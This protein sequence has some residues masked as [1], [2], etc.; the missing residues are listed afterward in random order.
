MRLLLRRLASSDSVAG[1]GLP[2][3][4]SPNWK[5]GTSE[6]RSLPH[7]TS[8]S[9][10]STMNTLAPAHPQHAWS[11][12]VFLSLPD[13][14]TG[15]N[16]ATS[17]SSAYVLRHLQGFRSQGP[18]ILDLIASASLSPLYASWCSS[19]KIARAT[20]HLQYTTPFH[21]FSR[22]GVCPAGPMYL[23]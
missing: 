2:P 18:Q 12:A 5:L 21:S 13:S 7:H 8:G 4:R 1:V 6:A 20:Q 9:I 10:S 15:Y 23:P 17:T 19:H 3:P 22:I 14:D 11:A 16:V